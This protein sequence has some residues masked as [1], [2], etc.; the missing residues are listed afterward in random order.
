MA[1][2]YG[3]TSDGLVIK[4]LSVI[5]KEWEDSLRSKLGANLNLLPQAVL[6][7]IVGIGSEREALIWELVELDY[8]ARY[9]DT[10]EGTSLDNVLALT[11]IKRLP[12]KKSTVALIL[13]GDVGTLIPAGSVVSV[14]GTSTTKFNIDAAVTIGASANEV[15]SLFFSTVPTSGVYK[16]KIGSLSTANINWNDNA[17]AVQSKINALT[18]YSGVT[19]SGDTSVGFTINFLGSSG[20]MEQPTIEITNNTLLTG[21][22]SVNTTV[23][24]NTEGHPEQVAATATCQTTGPL[25]APSGS[26]TVIE[27][28]ISGWNTVTNPLDAVVG[29]DIETDTEARIRRLALLANVGTATLQAIRAEVLLVDGVTEVVPFENTDI[30]PDGEGRPGKSFEIVARGGA[31]ADIRQA[32]FDTKPAGIETFGDVSGVVSDDQGFEHIINFSRPTAVPIYVTW[33]ITKNSLFPVNGSALVKQATVD[34]G[35]QLNIG[36]QV[37]V[38]GTLGLSCAIDDIPGITDFTIAVGTSPSPTLDNNIPITVK[39]LATFDTSR[40]IVNFTP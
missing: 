19:V 13:Y 30:L 2:T 25:V 7:Q 3:L 32:I 23:Q 9:P 26:L 31:D 4:R 6:G 38:N 18:G 10:A 15:Q 27:S 29:R 28:P 24:V 22:T 34:R 14:L 5:K 12:A 36:D 33:T 40:V 37:I 16:I 11:G 21:L 8:N 20:A 1:I 35:G 39:Q 17:A